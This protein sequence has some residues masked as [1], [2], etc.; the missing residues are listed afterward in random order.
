VDRNGRRTKTSQARSRS[1]WIAARIET[2]CTPTRAEYI[3]VVAIDRDVDRNPVKLGPPHAGPLV[4]IDLDRGA[5]RN[6][7]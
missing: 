1:I 3:A 4:V 7:S 5:D 2:G 6:K